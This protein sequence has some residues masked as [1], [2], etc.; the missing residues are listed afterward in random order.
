M[1]NHDYFE[2]N[3]ILPVKCKLMHV[4]SNHHHENNDSSAHLVKKWGW[5]WQQNWWGHHYKA[6]C[7]QARYYGHRSQNQCRLRLTRA[8]ACPRLA[9]V[10]HHPFYFKAM[11]FY[12][13]QSVFKKLEII[14]IFYLLENKY[15]IYIYF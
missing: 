14:L 5:R 1:I 12:I 6:Y 15:Y 2:E 4:C 11:F 7:H 10:V 9:P 8:R 3:L 13:F